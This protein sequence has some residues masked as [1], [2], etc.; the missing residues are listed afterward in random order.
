M[1]TPISQQLGMVTSPIR[2][3]ERGAVTL[4]GGGSTSVTFAQAVDPDKSILLISNATGTR[5]G[6]TLASMS[7]TIGGVLKANGSGAD[8]GVACPSSSTNATAYWQVV[9]YV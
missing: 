2:Y 1:S 4:G 8:F 6:S 3:I 9:E 7:Y 5:E